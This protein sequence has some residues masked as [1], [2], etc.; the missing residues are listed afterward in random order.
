MKKRWKWMDRWEQR[1]KERRWKRKR[2]GRSDVSE[3]ILLKEEEE[4]EEEETINV[5]ERRN[6]C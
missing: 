4:A 6:R 2:D 1:R 5:I 3:R